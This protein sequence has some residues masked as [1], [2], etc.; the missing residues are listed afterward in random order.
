[1]KQKKKAI[2]ALFCLMLACVLLL[3]ACTGSVTEVTNLDEAIQKAAA[4]YLTANYDV[5]ADAVKINSVEHEDLIYTVAGVLEGENSRDF[6]LKM[7]FVNY[8]GMMSAT[9]RMLEAEVSAAK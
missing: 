5:S 8:A 4:E 7:E 1:M 2:A 3:T 9:F 6:T